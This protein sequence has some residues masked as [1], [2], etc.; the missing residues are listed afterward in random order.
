MIKTDIYLYLGRSPLGG[1]L[2]R[3]I[4]YFFL[5]CKGSLRFAKKQKKTITRK[6]NKKRSIFFAGV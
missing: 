2:V 5:L 3:Q 6:D 4:G 1:D